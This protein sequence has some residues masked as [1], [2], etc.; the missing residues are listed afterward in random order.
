VVVGVVE[1]VNVS[2]TDGAI[3]PLRLIGDEIEQ[4]GKLT[5]LVSVVVMVQLRFTPPVKPNVGAMV[6]VVVLPVVAPGEMEMFPLLL[7]VKPA[8][9]TFMVCADD[10]DDEKYGSPT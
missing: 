4:V 9:P 5:G 3:A 2:L 10:V 6:I 8:V 1:M 7:S